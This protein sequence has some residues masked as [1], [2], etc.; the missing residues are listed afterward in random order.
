LTE[1]VD[2]NTEAW[3]ARQFSFAMANSKL[4]SLFISLEIDCFHSQEHENVCIAGLNRQ[5]GYAT[6]YIN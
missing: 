6:E 4:L 5:A 2:E 3:P 1:Y